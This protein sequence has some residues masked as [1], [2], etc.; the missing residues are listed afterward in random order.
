MSRDKKSRPSSIGD[1]V[2]TYLKSSGL[3]ARVDQASVIPNW[4]TLVGSQI[5][6][7]T[8]PLLVN[9]VGTLLVGVKTSAWMN[10]LSLMEPQ[11]LRNI[12]KAR[13]NSPIKKIRFRLMR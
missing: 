2:K 10:E 5:A 8:E 4:K 7:V 6:A 1:A 13:P 3:E 11:L 9:S 12:N